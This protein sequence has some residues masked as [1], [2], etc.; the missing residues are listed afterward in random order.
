MPGARWPMSARPSTWAPPR[1]ANARASRA[2]ISA[3]P[4]SQ[5]KKVCRSPLLLRRSSGGCMARPTRANSIAWRASFTICAPSLLALPSTPSPTATPASSRRRTGAMPEASRMLLQGQCA[6]PVR[7]AAKRLMPASSSRTQW[8]CQTS[9]PS[10]PRSCA[11]SVGVQ[12]N[13]SRE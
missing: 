7:L 12:L 11:Y 9:G 8:A 4:R 13:F 3:G 2:L 6:T 1:V 5:P 10:Q